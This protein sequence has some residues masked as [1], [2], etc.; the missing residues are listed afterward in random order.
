MSFTTNELLNRNKEPG[1]FGITAERKYYNLGHSFIKRS[2]R[3]REW[4][5]SP[6]RG[7]IIVPR[8][9]EQ[10]LQNE[11]AT[12]N[13]IRQHT[14]VP[15]PKVLACF[16][17]DEAIYLITECIQGVDMSELEEE[18]KKVVQAELETHR[19]NIRSSRLGGPSGIAVPPYRAIE[20]TFRNEWKLKDGVHDQYVFC[21]NDLSQNNVMVD[22]A[23]LEIK[24]IL[25]WEYAGFWPEWFDAKYYPF[26]QGPQLL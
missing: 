4:Q 3:R 23:T 12:L 8:M 19:A 26:V 18:Q 14:N 5:V 22:P 25:D 6:I 16:E 10:R 17:D 9:N 13:F 24:A 15:V 1:C 11:A 7:T 20:A 21:H 2:L